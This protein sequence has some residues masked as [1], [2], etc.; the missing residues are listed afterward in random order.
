MSEDANKVE[1]D[2]LVTRI[3]GIQ[4]SIN[5]TEREIQR[6]ITLNDG[7]RRTMR[8]LGNKLA[9]MRTFELKFE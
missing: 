8:T 5:Q 2:R 1:C 7:R 6:L 4:V 3:N 9:E